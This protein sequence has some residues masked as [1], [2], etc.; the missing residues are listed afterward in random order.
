MQAPWASDTPDAGLPATPEHGGMAAEWFGA[1]IRGN[2][3]AFDHPSDMES[4]GIFGGH[5]AGTFAVLL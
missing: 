5:A 1:H 3:C 2:Q 4:G